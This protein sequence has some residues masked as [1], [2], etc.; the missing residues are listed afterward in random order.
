MRHGN[1]GER[2]DVTSLREDISRGLGEPTFLE[3][4]LVRKSN[5]MNQHIKTAKISTD[6]GEN[7]IKTRDDLADLAADELVEALGADKMNEKDAND[8]IMQAREHWFSE[9]D[10]ATTETAEDDSDAKSG[11]ESSDAA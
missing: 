8:I 1:F 5:G 10:A 4:V 3:V 6:F 11:K 9:D 2:A 7:G